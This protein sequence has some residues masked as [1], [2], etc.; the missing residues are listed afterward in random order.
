MNKRVRLRN[1]KKAHKYIDD[2]FLEL[3]RVRCE[4]GNVYKWQELVENVNRL[5]DCRYNLKK[6]GLEV[7]IKT[8]H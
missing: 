5:A 4:L 8:R 1:K 3:Y 2:I 6:L 7:E